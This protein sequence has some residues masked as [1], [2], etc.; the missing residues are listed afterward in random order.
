MHLLVTRPEPDASSLA[1]ALRELGHEVL[2]SPLMDIATRDFSLDLDGVQG[3]LFT[4]ANGVRAFADRLGAP[5]SGLRAFAVGPASAQVARDAGWTSVESA[6][7][8]VSDLAKLV[9]RRLKPGNGPLVHLSG[10]AAAGDLTGS[11]EQLGFTVS[12]VVA[13]DAT[14]PVSLPETVVAALDRG[15]LDGVLLFSPRSALLFADLAEKAGLG[16]EAAGLT[17][18][19]LSQAVADALGAR[20]PEPFSAKFKVASAPET[21][22]LLAL[23]SP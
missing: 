8:E 9:A 12:R 14:A 19:C 4:S 1:R 3:V 20:F 5:P 21:P 13:Y 16:D 23:L 18:Y 17:A 15:V 22:H 11:L 10:K 7:G 2:V 6:G